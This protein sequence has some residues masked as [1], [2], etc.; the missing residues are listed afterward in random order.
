[1]FERLMDFI[2]NIP[3]ECYQFVKWLFVPLSVPKEV[4]FFGLGAWTISLP[5]FDFAPIEILT[6]GGFTVIIVFHLIHLLNV[7]FG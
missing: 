3:N 6:F 5:N 1:M 7:V 2:L 4:N